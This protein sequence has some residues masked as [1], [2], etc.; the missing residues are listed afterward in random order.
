MGLLYLPAIRIKREQLVG[1]WK[2][3]PWFQ[4]RAVEHHSKVT[5]L[6]ANE[7]KNLISAWFQNSP[8]RISFWSRLELN[9]IKHS[10]LTFLGASCE[11][12]TKHYTLNNRKELTYRSHLLTYPDRCQGF[13]K[14][15]PPSDIKAYQV[16]DSVFPWVLH[17]F[18]DFLQAPVRPK[19]KVTI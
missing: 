18:L 11:Y 3:G 9:S 8:E 5:R 17:Y 1:D 2:E 19:D 13:A 14:I 4:A 12:K 10:I 6:L 15:D 7:W 16:F